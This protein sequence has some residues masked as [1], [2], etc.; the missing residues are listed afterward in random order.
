[1]RAV[2]QRA[3]SASVT[4]D[5]DVVGGFGE[6]GL[7]G[8]LGVTPAHGPGHVAGLARPIWG[9]RLRRDEQSAADRGAPGGVGRV[10]SDAGMPSPRT[11]GSARSSTRP[12]VCSKRVG[13]QSTRGQTCE[14]ELCGWPTRATAHAS[15]ADSS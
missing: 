7:V 5:G 10:N 14:V 4:V 9:R 15:S 2:I 12:S 11:L 13:S 6:P 8:L 1:M 3:R